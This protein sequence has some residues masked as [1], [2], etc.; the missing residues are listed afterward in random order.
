MYCSF[1][2]FCIRKQK[3]ISLLHSDRIRAKYKDVVIKS[4]KKLDGKSAD[5]A[6]FEIE[7][8]IDDGDPALKKSEADLNEEGGEAV[9]NE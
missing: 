1:L 5:T 7:L 3:K 2:Y 4:T 8:T 9:E 6:S